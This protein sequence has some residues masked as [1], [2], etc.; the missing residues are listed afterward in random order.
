M[1]HRI[2]I[3]DVALSAGAWSRLNY[4]STST[5]NGHAWDMRGC[6]WSTLHILVVRGGAV[7]LESWQVPSCG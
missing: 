7:L 4:L 1:R 6:T 3:T 5:V 2:S